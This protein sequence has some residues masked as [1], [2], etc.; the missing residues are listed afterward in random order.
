MTRSATILD[1]QSLKPA[2][3]RGPLNS[4]GSSSGLLSHNPFTINQVVRYAMLTHPTGTQYQN[5]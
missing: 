4:Y 2:F 5:L 3:P 1:F